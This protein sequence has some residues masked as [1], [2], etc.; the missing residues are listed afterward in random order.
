[1]DKREPSYTLGGNVNW[2]NHYGEH[3]GV[4]LKKTK[5]GTPSDSALP[6]PGIY[7]EKIIIQKDTCT[8]LFIVALFAIARIWKQPKSPSTEKW[9]KKTWY[10]LGECVISSVLSCHSK[11]WKW[12]ASVTARLQL[13]FTWQTKD[14]TP[15]RHKGRPPTKASPQSSWLPLFMHLSPCSWAYPMQTGLARRAVFFTWGSHSG[16]W[17]F[18]CSIFASFSLSLSFSHRHFGLL[19]PTLI[20]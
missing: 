11:D 14:S 6:L 5:T 19:F 1:M 16:L 9:L 2:F 15:L 4:P 18:F 12:W 3:Y 8:L 17:I 13:S 20:T 7:P 10:M